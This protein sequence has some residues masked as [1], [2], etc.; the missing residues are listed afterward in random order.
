MIDRK[1]V[2]LIE[3]VRDKTAHGELRWEKTPHEDCFKV[4]FPD[5]AILISWSESA[6]VFEFAVCNAEGAVAEEI[7]N[8][9]RGHPQF[10]LFQDWLQEIFQQA[11]RTALG[12]DKV[13]D[14]IL[15]AL[16]DDPAEATADAS[17]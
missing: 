7:G 14:D 9:D 3:R 13:I 17:R 10:A 8:E 6:S 11:R 1:L 4:A 2:K 12:A 5:S 15:A 16:G